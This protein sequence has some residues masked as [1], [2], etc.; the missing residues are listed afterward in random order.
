MKHIFLSI[1]IIGCQLLQAQ[2]IHQKFN[3]DFQK[4]L[5]D[6]GFKH[7]TIGLFVSDMNTGKT[8]TSFNQ[9]VGLAPASTQK[10]ITAAT[11]YQLL[12]KDFRYETTIGY[13]GEIEGGRLKGDI[14]IKG[15]GDPTL[16]SWR[17]D[18][19]REQN[20]IN[21][22]VAAI[23]QF[24]IKEIEG[25]VLVDESM[26][27][28]EAIPDGWIWQDIGNYY[29][30]GARALNWR[31][32]QFDLYLRSG[33]QVSSDVEIT[34][35]QPAL[36]SGLNLISKVKSA[37]AGTGDNAYI[38]LPLFGGSGYV[39]GTIPVNQKVFTISGALPNP[40]KQL[41]LTL[42]SVLKKMPFKETEKA[43]PQSESLNLSDVHHIYT[44]QSPSMDSICYWFLQKS[45]NL[46]GE[47]LLKTLGK[48]YGK[49]GSTT[50]GIKVIQDFWK[51]QGIDNDALKMID[52][53]GLSPQNRITVDD[54][55]KVLMFARNQPWFNNYFS[56]FP[57]IN[58]IKMKSGSIGGVISYTGFIQG[59][60]GNY[61][62][63]FIVNNYNGNGMQTRKK[64][65][66]L[67]DVLK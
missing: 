53:S 22:I 15:S 31:E 3:T 7:A 29:G 50:E 57:V 38:Y 6:S 25:H 62:F 41:A 46:Y 1:L 56:G 13:R 32:N 26:F 23:L 49:G 30:A 28:D 2:T 19:T 51:K 24:G 11:A 44:L 9:Q 59:K 39:R 43:Y 16:G 33:I 54:L 14:V 42:E 17:Y 21:E 47:A 61:V 5:N 37:A 48:R 12:G 60:N 45:I 4:F 36:I 52:G 34:G 8:V 58:G 20:V 65:W 64:M 66:K 40:G 18:S 67:L 10:I 55:V 27:D 63:A 35:T